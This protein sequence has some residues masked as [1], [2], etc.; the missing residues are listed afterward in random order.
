ML[1]IDNAFDLEKITDELNR[2]R[3][4]VGLRINMEKT[5]ITFNKAAQTKN[6]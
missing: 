3:V 6:V 2:G 1:F 5:Y 4:K